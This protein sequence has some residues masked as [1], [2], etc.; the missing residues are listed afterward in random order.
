MMTVF[1]YQMVAAK[2][3]NIYNT[4]I[5]MEHIYICIMCVVFFFTNN[6]A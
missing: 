2:L 6:Y 5:M 3:T 4:V 1:G